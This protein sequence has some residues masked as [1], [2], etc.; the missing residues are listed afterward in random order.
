MPKAP[1]QSASDAEAFY[2]GVFEVELQ[3][4]RARRQKR[5]LEPPA[6]HAS[7]NGAMQ[8]RCEFGLVGLAL[9]GGGIR[10]ATFNLGVLQGMAKI[11]N[12][13]SGMAS[14]AEK[15]TDT[16]PHALLPLF[17]YL[18]T[19][20]GG[21]Y[22]GSW[23]AGWIK[24]EGFGP[25]E[26]QLKG[27]P[28]SRRWETKETPESGPIQ[29]LRDYSN[30]LT[31]TLGLLSADTWSAIATYSRNAFVN[32]LVIVPLA[33]ALLLLPRLLAIFTPNAVESPEG[34]ALGASTAVAV[35][36]GCLTA[37][38]IWCASY[39][40]GH[41]ASWFGKRWLQTVVCIPLLVAA[42][43]LL[44]IPLAPTEKNPAEIQPL[45]WLGAFVL[46]N[47]VAFLIYWPLNKSAGATHHP[48]QAV[49]MWCLSAV[50]AGLVG[51]LS[52]EM[53]FGEFGQSYIWQR[54]PWHLVAWGPP[55][56]LVLFVT[57]L[58]LQLGLRGKYESDMSREWW[59]SMVGWLLIFATVWGLVAGISIYG[60]LMF[61]FLHNW[62]KTQYALIGSW[63]FTTLGAILAGRSAK[64][65]G[66]QATAW[67]DYV[68]KTLAPIAV[69]GFLFAVSI[70]LHAGL[71]LWTEPVGPLKDPC[72]VPNS[73]HSIGALDLGSHTVNVEISDGERPSTYCGIMVEYWSQ[74]NAHGWEKILVLFG[75][76]LVLGLVMGLAIDINQFSMQ[77]FYRN[78][79][80]R[81]YLRAIRTQEPE[82][83]PITDFDPDDDF[84]LADLTSE[85]EKYFGPYLLI[86]TALNI[87]DPTRLG[88]QE[89]K[90]LAFVLAPRYCGSN[91]TG[92]RP[93]QTYADSIK[94]GTALGISGAA[95]STNMGYQSSRA[96]AFFLSLFNVRLGWWIGN[97]IGTKYKHQGPRWGLFYLFAELFGRV[98]EDSEYVY[99]SDGGHFD[100]LGLYELIR[101]RCK[102]IVCCDAGEDSGFSFD[103]LGKA[104]RKIRADFGIDIEINLEMV[105]PLNN[106]GYSRWHHAIGTVRYDRVDENS[107][108]GTL[109]YIKASLVGDEP[110]DVLEYKSHHREFPHES[111]LDQFF[112][113]SQFEAYRALGEHTAREVFRYAQGAL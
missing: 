65:G 77:A 25:V 80:V 15:E 27:K 63:V 2:A 111:T 113:E 32:Q 94:L 16:S 98:N 89:R 29:H 109:V 44:W 13:R 73:T 51:G 10:S 18:S 85:G 107:P 103:D 48:W 37:L 66:L 54:V 104:I 71:R 92:Y 68:T 7:E 3:E 20:S 33:A 88:W 31:P 59:A 87:T 78:R 35:P 40:A 45:A 26:E 1:P 108:V 17:D 102:Y 105:R 61:E 42:V 14:A 96:L 74:L 53:I 70:G 28:L 60:P 79:L 43:L 58:H 52:M 76:S 4:I 22:I 12:A 100:N 19:V 99:L 47:I 81:C 36:A 75:L 56:A 112:S 82:P 83:H 106:G 46:L 30:Y 38:A 93:T 6:T 97:P 64:T 62:T 110:A 86:N 24:N 67:M 8:P 72:A 21:G 41:K 84:P 95:F 91:V 101:R 11:R 55:L 23:L 9:S 50:A 5:G 90:A 57:A 34:V 69:I 39:G 49:F